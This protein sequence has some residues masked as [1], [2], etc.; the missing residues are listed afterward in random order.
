IRQ[1]LG[2]AALRQVLRHEIIR[3]TLTRPFRQRCDDVVRPELRAGTA[4][5]PRLLVDA[6]T[7]ARLV[8]LLPGLVGAHVLRRIQ[9]RAMTADDGGMAIG[10]HALST[11]APDW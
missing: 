11:R 8:E 5:A 2:M 9:A 7:L 1:V 6:A 3:T 4:D 10:S